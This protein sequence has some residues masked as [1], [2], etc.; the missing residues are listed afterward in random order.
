MLTSGR[1]L[2]AHIRE[3]IGGMFRV[4]GGVRAIGGTCAQ[5]PEPT[6]TAKGEVSCFVLDG[7]V[8]IQYTMKTEGCMKRNDEFVAG[9]R[10]AQRAKSAK[11]R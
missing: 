2:S 11:R 10:E 7:L 4:E 3:Q 5:G 1:S 9:A 8:V 6:R